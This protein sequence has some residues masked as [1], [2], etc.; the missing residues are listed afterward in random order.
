MQETTTQTRESFLAELRDTVAAAPEDPDYVQL[1]ASWL[2]SDDVDIFA[3]PPRS[4]IECYNAHPAITLYLDMEEEGLVVRM[5]FRELFDGPPPAEAHADGASSLLVQGAL[6]E[7]LQAFEAAGVGNVH[8]IR[9][10]TDAT[11]EIGVRLKRP[12]TDSLRMTIEYARREAL[13]LLGLAGAVAKEARAA[14]R[15]LA[16]AE[17][18]R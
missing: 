8:G 2:G 1:D 11:G 10:P 6:L 15:V 16:E 17:A 13:R 7:V 14:A 18:T 4:R 12:A 5:E 3:L 9:Y